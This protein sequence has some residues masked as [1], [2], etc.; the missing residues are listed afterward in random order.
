M[1]KDPYIYIDDIRDSIDAINS[2]V[3]NMQKAEFMKSDMAQDAVIRRLEII[4]EAA[5]EIDD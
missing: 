3:Q 4:G 1:T 5:N 2:Y